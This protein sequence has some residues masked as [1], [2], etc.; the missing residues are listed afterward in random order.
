MNALVVYP[1]D[2]MIIVSQDRISDG[3]AA[4]LNDR[5]RQE[6]PEEVRIIILDSISG[7][8]VVRTSPEPR[9]DHA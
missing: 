5:L 4:Y 6:L 9:E 1:G 2:T 3:Q 8:A 7:M